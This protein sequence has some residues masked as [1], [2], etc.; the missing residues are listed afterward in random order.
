MRTLER[1]TKLAM[2]SPYLTERHPLAPPDSPVKNVQLTRR[3]GRISYA[4]KYQ[5]PG[6]DNQHAQPRSV[7]DARRA[8]RHCCLDKTRWRRTQEWLEGIEPSQTLVNGGVQ[9]RT[10][11]RSEQC[12]PSRRK[13]AAFEFTVPTSEGIVTGDQQ[14]LLP[15]G[16]WPGNA[17]AESWSVP[18]AVPS[19]PAT[20]WISPLST[21][22]LSLLP[23]DGDFCACEGDEGPTEEWDARRK[24]A[25]EAQGTWPRV[26]LCRR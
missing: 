16:R 3:N 22:E 7:D 10:V 1:N 8:D 26:V 6:D 12:T 9:M 5:K 11:V 4:V 23:V 25:I 17:A 19:P 2:W 21:P 13:S 15:A 24:L 18:P 20:P 14:D